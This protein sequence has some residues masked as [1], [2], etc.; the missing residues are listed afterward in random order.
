MAPISEDFTKAA[1]GG[2]S[3][4]IDTPQQEKNIPETVESLYPHPV[5]PWAVQPAEHFAHRQEQNPDA[6]DQID[7]QQTTL[8]GRFNG[9]AQ[10]RDQGQ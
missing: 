2:Q 3:T 10:G 8:S 7:A 4:D 1:Q 5:P 6:F 9:H